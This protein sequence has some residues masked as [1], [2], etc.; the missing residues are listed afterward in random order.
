MDAR[1]KKMSIETILY[2]IISIGVV[3]S[4]I[5]ILFTTI[6]TKYTI[7]QQKLKPISYDKI[8]SKYISNKHQAFNHVETFS[9][10][11]KLDVYE[12]FYFQQ[13]LSNK[14]E[15]PQL[16]D[17]FKSIN[18]KKIK[19]EEKTPSV[20]IS[21]RLKTIENTMTS[22]QTHLTRVITPETL[23]TGQTLLY[24]QTL[25]SFDQK[26]A[27]VLN[28]RGLYFKDLGSGKTLY[29]F[30]TKPYHGLF[31]TEKTFMGS[32]PLN[33]YVFNKYD[34]VNVFG[35][36]LN[37][38]DIS[39]YNI[40]L[41]VMITKV[42]PHIYKTLGDTTID[43]DGHI[44]KSSSLEQNAENWNWS[45]NDKACF[46][47]VDVIDNSVV[48]GGWFS[49]FGSYG[50]S[51][52]SS[53]SSNDGI[54]AKL[55]SN[56]SFTWATRFTTNV[57]LTFIV[58]VSVIKND[59]W[60]IGT[61]KGTL[62]SLNSEDKTGFIS[63]LDNSGS[64]TLLEKLSSIPL[65]IK[66]TTDNLFIL[67]E[68]KFCVYDVNLNVLKTVNLPLNVYKYM[69]KIGRDIFLGGGNVINVNSMQISHE[70]KIL[71]LSLFTKDQS[72]NYCLIFEEDNI[73]LLNSQT[74]DLI[75][76]LPV[77]NTLKNVVSYSY[78][79]SVWFVF[80]IDGIFKTNDNLFGIDGKTSQVLGR[81]SNQNVVSYQLLRTYDN[82]IPV[83]K[84]LFISDA[85]SILLNTYNSHTS[86]YQFDINNKMIRKNTFFA[87][88]G[89]TKVTFNPCPWTP[90][91][92]D[93]NTEIELTEDKL[94]A[95]GQWSVDVKD[96]S[97]SYL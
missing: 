27:L 11:E 53:I 91:N 86:I 49:S 17:G 33:T 21:T 77:L 39:S 75:K 9:I 56:G 7:E 82:D 96:G 20:E 52:I 55:S 10:G 43:F 83:S 35:N 80:D 47:C 26:T 6:L 45:I 16:H 22:I 58:D 50:A 31:L 41:N 18:D 54:V 68:D 4:I 12:P 69:S 70:S 92:V 8:S 15:K 64:I 28:S 14:Y 29:Q 57:W 85:F 62:R 72:V 67:Y 3:L 74:G 32:D 94:I 46:V 1:Y 95:T 5:T 60:V 78:K 25:K 87:L 34:K 48:M 59:I 40:P 97:I 2:T 51:M 84:S 44:H 13:P 93:R 63:R 76:S 23:R 19:I 37:V 90:I 79:D 65:A 81:F 71:S 24:G 36:T 89:G 88:E 30:S 73:K 38:A 61:F 66:T 42:T